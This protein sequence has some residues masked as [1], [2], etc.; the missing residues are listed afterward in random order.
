VLAGL[1][2]PVPAAAAGERVLTLYSPRIDSL[3]Y[4]HDTHHVALR[5]DGRE[6]PA[7]PG[8]V[9][10]F[11][12]MALVDSKRPDAKPLP[13]AK[14]MVHHF[15]YWA[16][17]RV[18]EAPGGCFSGAGFIGGRGEEHP[19]G[20]ARA[21]SRR[22]FRDRYGINNRLPDGAAPD[23]RLT[24]MVM[25]HYRRPKSFYVR[26]R[27]YYTTEPRRS[28][29]PLVIGN[30][31]HLANGMAYDVPGGG[32]PGTNFVDQSDWVAPLSGRLLM[33]SSHQHGGGKYQTLASRTCGRQL[34]KAPVYHGRPGHA[35]NTIRPILHE[36]GPIGTGAYATAE[37]IPIARGEVLRRTAVH[38]NH[39][40]HVAAMGFWATWF[41]PDDSVKPCDRPPDD[42]AEINRPRRYD[43]T[44]NH[45]LV[46]PQ[47]TRPRGAFTAFD[48]NALEIGDDFFGLPKIT[49]RVGQTVTWRFGSANPHS[50]TVA[51]GP[52]G[53]SSSYLGR[54]TGS[55]SVTPAVKGTYRLV[56]L[57]HPTT[58]AQTLQVK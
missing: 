5:A 13:I 9:L 46:V 11:K 6:A 26:T 27:V 16:P 12:E 14:M 17:G 52:R 37:G 42:I 18:D 25:N 15:L 10:G 32:R 1:V 36:P 39:N 22:G 43:R 50:V 33:A 53:F 47:L 35:Y 3:P 51:N 29:M 55:Y 21:P 2:L 38:D 41:L 45:D 57:I 44:P 48:G 4:V 31:A 20:H 7:R 56:C 34:L 54:T 58:M 19:L 23:W 8:Y 24:A 28:V 49:A 30:C 40:L